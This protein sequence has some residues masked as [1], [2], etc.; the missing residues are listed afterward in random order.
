MSLLEKENKVREMPNNVTAEQMLLGN[1][2][3]NNELIYKVSDFL[4][5]SDFFEPIHGKI[6]EAILATLDKGVVA[7]PVTLKNKFDADESLNFYGG[8]DYLAKIASLSS[9]IINIVDYAKL[10]ADLA[11]KRKLISIGQD[12]VNTAFDQGQ[13]YSAEDQIEMAEQQLFKLDDTI[14]SNN[15]F[16]PIKK[17]LAEA[18]EKAQTAYKNK[19][20]VVGVSTGFLDLD[21]MLGGMQNSD[22]IILAARPSMGKTALSVNMAY[23][24]AMFL[25][26]L[27]KKGAE[28]AA[29]AYFSLEMSGEQIGTRLI[30]MV[31]GIGASKIRTGNIS[32]DEFSKIIK[33]NRDMS[34][35]ELYIDDT[36]SITISALRTRAR[37]MKKKVNLRAIFIDYLQLMRGGASKQNEASRVAEISEITQGLKAIAK[38]LNVPVIALSQLSRAVEQREDKHPLLSDLRESGSIEQDADVV[39]F[40]YREDY[41]LLRKQPREDTPEHDAWQLKMNEVMNLTEVIIAKQ[42]N[43][44]VG[45][46]KLFF[47]SKTTMFTNYTSSQS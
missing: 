34:N 12:M 35:L 30:S 27:H 31:S 7:S 1:F 14:S 44:P 10:I 26:K 47:D 18:L 6:Y 5:V 20:Q 23:N 36:P 25:D 43:G 21:T 9:S 39:M 33:T 13:D 2:L 3:V 37:R 45:T 16:A 38:E 19:G 40:I 42:R 24:A 32:E 15:N 11:K 22:L 41:Y 29:V 4:L 8:G 28:K 17:S 46:V